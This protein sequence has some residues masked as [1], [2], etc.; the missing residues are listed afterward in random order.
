MTP[1]PLLD[2]WN[3]AGRAARDDRKRLLALYGVVSTLPALVLGAVLFRA[4]A[5]RPLELAGLLRPLAYV[6]AP[7]HGAWLADAD[8]DV[9]LYVFVQGLVLAALWGVF[10]GAVSRM[11]AVHVATGRKES[12]AAGMAFAKRHWRASAGAKAALWA[13]ALVPAVVAVAAASAARAPGVFGGVLAPAAILVAAAG[14]L[15]AA[16]VATTAVVGGFLTTPTIACEDS[17]AFD[18][19][20]RAFGYAG[21]GLPRLVGVRL[22]FLAG[23]LFGAAWRLLRTVLALAILA[24]ALRVGAGEAAWDRWFAV[25]SAMGRGTGLPAGTSTFDVAAAATIALVVGGLFALWAADFVSRILCA[26]V[27][28]YLALR[29][30]VD[31]VPAETLRSPPESPARADAE[32]AG[33]VEV[34]RIV[35]GG[36]PRG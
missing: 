21:A 13:G 30:A 15:A 29:Q 32:A 28:A 18:A 14:A 36:R 5:L 1:T 31:R 35:P 12:A 26:R 4:L 2:L 25:L 22:L 6:T 34:A 7:L 33:F 10:G 27:G 24:V 17:D 3:R 16:V 23:A 20:S 8:L 19:V 11:A 9:L